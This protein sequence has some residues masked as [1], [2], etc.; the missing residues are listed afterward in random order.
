MPRVPSP[1]GSST[2]GRWLRAADL[3]ERLAAEIETTPLYGGLFRE[4]AQRAL[5][6]T[7]RARGRRVP[8]WLA[9][10]RAADLEQLLRGHPDFPLAREARRE[11]LEDVLEVA[12]LSRILAGIERGDIRVVPM[13]RAI[14]SPFASQ[15]LVGFTMAFLYEG[16]QPR[17]ERRARALFAGREA[18]HELLPPEELVGLL[19]PGTARAVEERRQHLAPGTRARTP[20]ELAEVLRH[21]VALEAAEVAPRVEGDAEAALAELRRTG[22]IVE[23]ERGGRRLLVLEEDLEWWRDLD[24]PGEAGRRARAELVRRHAAGRG[25]FGVE[26]AARRYGLDGREVVRALEDLEA[27]GVVARGRF[28]ASSVEGGAPEWCDRRNLAE[29]HRRTL[30]LLRDRGAPADISRFAAFLVERHRARDVP[31]AAALLAG[32]RAPLPTLER[33]LVWRRVPGYTPALL[34][35]ACATGEV[36]FWIENG[37]VCLTPREDL[38]VFW[39]APAAGP[40]S[41]EEAAVWDA[42]SARGAQF[43]A[44]LLGATRLGAAELFRAV[45]SLAKKGLV[46]SDAYEA[47]RRAAALDFEPSSTELALSDTL[48]VLRRASRRPR[49]TPWV[50]RFARILPPPLSDEERAARQAE[51]LLRRYGVVGKALVEGE[52]GLLPWAALEAALRRLELRGEVVRG[53]FVDGIGGYQVARADAVDD[54]RAPRDPG[55]IALI[56]ACDPACAHAVLGGQPPVLRVPSTYLVL[57]GGSPLLL[58]EGF[59]RKI[60]PL[61]EAPEDVLVSGL[62]HLRALL[63]VPAAM[64]AVRSIVVRTYDGREAASA[65]GLFLRAGFRRDADRM[66]LGVLEAEAAERRPH[67]RP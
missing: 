3:P 23:I 39:T 29:I 9:R 63:L 12:A 34:D 44:E 25:P 2:P 30:S 11:A 33:D 6:F 35:A 27:A 66:V 43:G 10:Q 32:I 28:L 41:P 17:L 21:V 36:A 16:D 50:G 47:L 62:A 22:R 37:K 4:A 20:E 46:T 5:L 65:E 59:G 19:D 24:D 55:A 61:A 38:G 7:P 14:P 13:R 49:P 54:L 26:E 18:A 57:R 45:W 64:R 51:A 1:N 60:T 8:L 67:D 58:V 40:L 31:G 53:Y 15:L 42:L 48:G 56:N 52:S